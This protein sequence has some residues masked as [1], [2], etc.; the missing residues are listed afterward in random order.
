MYWAKRLKFCTPS[1][2]HVHIPY[3]LVE[4]C[5][6][7]SY[8]VIYECKCL[9]CIF[10]E[11]LTYKV[12]VYFTLCN[13]FEEGYGGFA[14][15]RNV[16]KLIHACPFLVNRMSYNILKHSL[17]I[18]KLHAIKFGV[19]LFSTHEHICVVQQIGSKYPYF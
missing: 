15:N 2:L 9:R 19:I 14:I 13:Y 8:A 10:R 7:M 17:S 4:F 18:E 12:H 5:P 3:V 16:V 11:L 1:P 6:I